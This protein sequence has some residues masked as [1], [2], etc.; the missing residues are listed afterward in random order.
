MTG[1]E[2]HDF[3]VA[4]RLIRRT[5]PPKQM[6]GDMAYDGDGLREKLD[7]RGTKSVIFQTAAPESNRSASANV[8]ISFAGA[9][10]VRSTGS[11]TSGASQPA[12]TGWREII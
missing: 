7:E 3:P 1:G 6:L 5:K 9:S 12:T 2:A 8:S 4:E 11:K 10:K